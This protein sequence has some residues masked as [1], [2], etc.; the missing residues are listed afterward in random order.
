MHRVFVDTKS[1]PSPTISDIPRQLFCL[2][3]QLDMTPTEVE[4][5]VIKKVV[6]IHVEKPDKRVRLTYTKTIY[7]IVETPS[8]DNIVINSNK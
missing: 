1:I 5:I 3:L 6:I 4:T 8:D 7:E 2:A